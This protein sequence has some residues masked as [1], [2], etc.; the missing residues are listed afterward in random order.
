MTNRGAEAAGTV[1]DARGQTVPGCTVLVFAADRDRWQRYSRFVKAARCEGDG[2]FSVR[3]LP[4]AEYFV[5]AVDRLEGSDTSGEWEDP[6]V[7]ESLLPYASRVSL[8]EG[9]FT[10]TSLKLIGR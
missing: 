10:S 5:A 1:T 6:A 3:G 2:T 8:S 4:T 9:Q 7:L